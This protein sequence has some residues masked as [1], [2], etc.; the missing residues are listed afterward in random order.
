MV[1]LLLVIL[2]F[3]ILA[4]EVV[5]AIRYTKTIG[6]SKSDKLFYWIIALLVLN[7]SISPIVL[8]LLR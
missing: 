4:I 3:I 6:S 5:L 7:V 8:S 2:Q 1:A